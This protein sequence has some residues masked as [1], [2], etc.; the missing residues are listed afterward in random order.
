MFTKHNKTGAA[1]AIAVIAAMGV[2]G[3]AIATAGSTKA[4][5]ATAVVENTAGPDTDNVQSGDQTTPDVA[6]AAK[7]GSESSTGSEASGS[8]SASGSDGPGGHA[9]EPGNASADHQNEGVE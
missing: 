3:T 2:G 9:D 1:A 7:A 5:P 6:G 4:K 8:E